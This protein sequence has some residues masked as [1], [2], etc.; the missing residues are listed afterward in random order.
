[1]AAKRSML[2]FHLLQLVVA[3]PK[4]DAEKI[5][6]NYS[7][8]YNYVPRPQRG[9]ALTSP[10]VD[11]GGGGG[12]TEGKLPP[13]AQQESVAYWHGKHFTLCFMILHSLQPCL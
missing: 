3:R 7:F 13:R 10:T 12:G 2:H 8:Y 1:M 5:C 11:G 4:G 6:Q 9:G